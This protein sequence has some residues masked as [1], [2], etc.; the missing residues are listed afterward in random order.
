MSLHKGVKYGGIAAGVVVIALGAAFA[1]M[2]SIDVDS[3]RG[4]IIAAAESATGRK[5]E[6]AKP[7]RL[8]V[9]FSPALVVEGLKMSNAPWGSAP[10]MV[11]IGRAEAEVGL[12][13]LLTGT[14]QV[15]RLVLA[16]AAVN[17][18]RRKDGSANWEFGA[19]KPA[20][21]PADDKAKSSGGAMPKIGIQAVEFRNVKLSFDDKAS[22]QKIALAVKTLSAKAPGMS[23]PLNLALEMTY[24]ALP[25]HLAG[26]L[27]PISALTADNPATVDLALDVPGIKLGVKGKVGKPMSGKDIDLALTLAGESYDAAG[28]AFGVDLAA[29]PPMN[30]AA[31]VQSKGDVYKVADLVLKLGGQ[32]IKGSAEADLSRA[33]IS[34]KADVSAGTLDL[35]KL[36]DALAPKSGDKKAAAPA[37]SAKGGRVFPA[38]PLPLDAMRGTDATASVKVDTLVL[39][40]GVKLSGVKVGVVLKDGLLT[41]DPRIG[42]G[43]GSITGKVVVDGRPARGNALALDANLSGSGINLG[44]VASDM[45]MGKVMSGAATA[46]T[47]TAKGS[48]RS[49]RDLM[50]GLDGNLS[51]DTGKGEIVNA[52][53][54]KMLGDAA[55]SALMLVDTGFATRQKTVLQCVAARV[56]IKAGMISIDRKIAA[57][58]DALNAVVSGQ[59]NLKTEALDLSVTPVATGVGTGLMQS[60]AGAVKVSGT[61]GEPSVGTDLAGAGKAAL[62]VGAAV[63]T[64]GLSLLGS[65]VLDSA[66]KDSHPCATARGETQ[67]QSGSSSSKSNS[68]SSGSGISGAVKGLFGN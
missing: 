50:A 37:K 32:E 39:P 41:V 11:S 12:F 57:E 44:T 9:S 52:E 61:L 21:K 60:A 29:V 62:K 49:V 14:V 58:S 23:S 36:S 16:D 7:I 35:A 38:D 25:I 65:A 42:V 59:V 45:G 48:G 66:T 33:R 27:G 56:P 54:R 4:Q 24:N 5:V 30:L 10:E 51:L 53:L 46:F 67:S 13:P 31:R 68:K 47:L 2:S 43:G 55:M 1:V 8:H 40:G 26:S 18:E 17:L 28:K 34:A 22:G 6:I 19:A 64:G 20:A 15:N 3:Y 63:A